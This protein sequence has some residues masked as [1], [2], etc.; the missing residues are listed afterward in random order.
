MTISQDL[1]N[2]RTAHNQLAT[3]FETLVALL[4][5]RGT[6]TT[7]DTHGIKHATPDTGG[8]NDG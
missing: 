6:L 7:A 1:T 4:G 8:A 2:L 5:H 3:Q